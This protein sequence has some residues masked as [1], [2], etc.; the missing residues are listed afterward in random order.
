MLKISDFYLDKK[1]VLFIKNIVSVPCTMDSFFSAN[2][3]CLDVLTFRIK[4]FD[5]YV[6]LFFQTTLEKQNRALHGDIGDKTQRLDDLHTS[7]AEAD[8]TKKKLSVEK[9]DLEKQIDEADKTLR[10]LGKIK[11]SLTTQVSNTFF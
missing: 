5:F 1:K 11:S 4:C 6:L 2:R 8:I 10:A 3:W 9:A 7:L